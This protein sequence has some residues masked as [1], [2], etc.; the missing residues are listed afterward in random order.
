M[1]RVTRG[2]RGCAKLRATNR[3]GVLMKIPPVLSAFYQAH[4]NTPE[5]SGVIFDF[6]TADDRQYRIYSHRE[7][8]SFNEDEI[9]DRLPD[10]FVVGNNAGDEY[11]CVENV[12]G[13]VVQI[14]MSPIDVR[15]AIDIAQSLDELLARALRDEQ[16]ELI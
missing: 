2:S 8:I 11:L 13:K 12:T 5:R 7:A 1:I 6:L 9:E 3:N 15:D 14:P 16:G 10:H 4:R